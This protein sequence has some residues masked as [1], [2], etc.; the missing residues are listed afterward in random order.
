MPADLVGDVMRHGTRRPS[1]FFG[2]S[3]MGSRSGSR[4][5]G[6]LTACCALVAAVALVPS[7]MS[8]TGRLLAR[9]KSASSGPAAGS[10]TVAAQTAL[11]C[12]GLDFVSAR[13]SGQKYSANNMS[14]SPQTN[15]VL[16][17]IEQALKEKGVSTRIVAQQL[18]PAY[19]AP[20]VSELRTGLSPNPQKYLA[21]VLQFLTVN[22]QNYIDGEHQGVEELYDELTS[23]YTSC[24]P[25]GQEP[26]VVLAGYSQGAMVVHNV[27]NLLAASGQSGVA[28]MIKGAVL[29][30]DPERMPFSDVINNFGTAKYSD[31]GACHMLDDTHLGSCVPPS[32]TTDIASYFASTTTQVCDT[33]D[34]FC[35]SSSVFPYSGGSFSLHNTYY[36]ITHGIQVHTN[37][38]TYYCSRATS[39]GKWVGFNIAAD[40]LGTTP[41]PS[42]S[43][44]PSPSPSPTLTPSPSLTPTPSGSSWTAAE[45]PSPANIDTGDPSAEVEGISC[46]STTECVAVG[47]YADDSGNKEMLAL[48]W[49]GG[50]WTAAGVPLPANAAF[51]PEVEVRGLSCPSVDEC[52]A[53]GMYQDSSG[54]FDG[55]LLTWSGGSWTAAGVPLPANAATT[56]PD[57]NV[58]AV[59]CASANECVAGGSYVDSSGN[60]QGLL[61]TWSGGSWTAAEAPVPSD[62]ASNPWAQVEGVSC[63][64]T[65]QCVAVGSYGSQVSEGLLW[66]WSAGSWTVGELPVLPDGAS[67]SD[68]DV[69]AVSC[70]S[71]GQCVAVGYYD[72]NQDGLLLTLSDGS[73]TAAEAP[74]PLDG[75]ADHVPAVSCAS[76]GNC[77]AVGAYGDSSGNGQG[78]LLTLSGGSWTAAEA[79]VPT[80][81]ASDPTEQV[82]GI[83]CPSASVCFAGGVYEDSNNTETGLLLAGT[84]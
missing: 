45:A 64:T 34:V 63:P 65:T 4:L 10:V 2:R 79:P 23:L 17:G 67:T 14:V 73:W 41:S 36:L 55:L 25:T 49:S 61:L 51:D 57:V 19:T 82:Q 11:S 80:D 54:G 9:P 1:G 35:D 46:P 42:P 59:S 32:T 40:G 5:L 8:V 62:A 21:D 39:A 27:L 76:V 38:R 70:P 16:A 43:Q 31:Y 12:S 29:I 75:S 15:A 24:L 44:S 22:L 48:T 6:A 72:D 69:Y 26:M 78:L 83:S 7:A 77:V 66:T 71:A 56:S 58:Y 50:S 47:V 33:G 20:S 52:V 30:A 84:G 53:G 3:G 74:V 13:G 18:G 81:A 28:A 37:C 60:T 68:S